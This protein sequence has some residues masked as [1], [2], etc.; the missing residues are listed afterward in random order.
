M[1]H[2]QQMFAND[3][4]SGHLQMVKIHTVFEGH[5]YQSP[6]RLREFVEIWGIEHPVGIDSYA[7]DGDEVPLTM[8]RY[9]TGGT[10]HV[11]IVDRSGRLRFRHLGRFDEQAAEALIDR[12]LGEAAP[13]QEER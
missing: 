5:D 9:S 4:K 8:R 11:V 1:K 3:I 6:E 10:P 7:S 13:S 12:L 2:W